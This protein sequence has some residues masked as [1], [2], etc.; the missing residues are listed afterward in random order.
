VWE[1]HREKQKQKQ[2]VKECEREVR[3]RLCKDEGER[4]ARK[5]TV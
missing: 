2:N 3:K 5:R 4:E 1:L